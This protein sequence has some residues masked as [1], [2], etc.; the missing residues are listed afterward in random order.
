[1]REWRHHGVGAGI[2]DALVKAANQRKTRRI[3]LHAQVQAAAFY[4]R[5]GFSETGG[6]FDEAGI[7]HI[8]MARVLAP[9]N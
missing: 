1:M 4:Q 7:P 8:T 9:V 2:L 5:Y 6:I 3:E